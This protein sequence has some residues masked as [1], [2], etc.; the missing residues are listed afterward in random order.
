MASN[1]IAEVPWSY[2][3]GGIKWVLL[4]CDMTE[5]GGVSLYCYQSLDGYRIYREYYDDIEQAKIRASKAWGIKD[6]DWQ[7]Q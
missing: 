3:K 5:L 7:I 6:A 1:L 4:E 2:R